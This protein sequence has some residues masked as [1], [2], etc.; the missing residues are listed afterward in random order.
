[1]VAPPVTEENFPFLA[2]ASKPMERFPTPPPR[3]VVIPVNMDS[4]A[5]AERA[6]I[7]PSV[8]QMKPPKCHHQDCPVTGF[9]YA[10][11]YT[12]NDSDL[13][14][15]VK[16]LGERAIQAEAR[17]VHP[18]FN[19]SQQRLDRFFLIHSATDA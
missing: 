1:M 4:T 2:P 15:F 5:V 19:R 16:E 10:K 8:P 14:K 13:P 12:P 11:S 6:P 18:I 7:L 3:P 9:H 17:G